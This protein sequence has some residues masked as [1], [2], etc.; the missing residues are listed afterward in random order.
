MTTDEKGV[1]RRD[2]LKFGGL[3]VAGLATTAT[4]ANFDPK[5][6]AAVP[7][8]QSEEHDHGESG[9]VGEVDHD[10]NEFD[11]HEILTD[12]DYG[13]VTEEDGQV[14]RTWQI[15]AIDK[16]FEIAPGVFFPGWVYGSATSAASQRL[17]KVVGQCPG[18]TMRCVEGE[19]LRI[20]FVN[21]SIHPHTIHFHGIH[22][23]FMDGIPGVGRGNINP[24]ESFTYE[25]TAR[26]FGCHLYHCHALPL[27]RH[28]HKGLYGAFIIDPDPANY[29]GD[30][31]AVAESRHHLSAANADVN[32]MA[33]VMNAFDTN[34]DGDNE[35][36]AVNTVA[37]GYGMQRPIVIQRDQLQRIYLV[38]VTEFDAIN[39]IHIHANFFDYYDHG[40]TLQPTLKTVDT[41]MQ[42][43]AQRGIVEVSFK[44]FEPGLYMFHAHQ[45]EFAELGWMG[46]FDVRA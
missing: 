19:L 11:P 24:G 18:P 8:A 40:T 20:E 12:F 13:T 30:E 2:F 4:L 41:I 28:I 39:S 46:F 15:V 3:G 9:T 23:A 35:V 36:Y 17:G 25:F 26:P 10:A 43:Q 45:S 31:Q 1:S 44:D 34:F 7:S 6:Q 5:A 21:G 27:K 33:M 29:T 32:E 16:E 38:N 14:I 42:C 22:S 37:F